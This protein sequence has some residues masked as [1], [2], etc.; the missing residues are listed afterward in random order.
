MHR[1]RL[2]D[3]NLFF[4]DYNESAAPGE[5]SLWHVAPDMVSI[6]NAGFH[7][8]LA[9]GAFGQFLDFF[10][11][12]VTPIKHT[13]DIACFLHLYLFR[14]FINMGTGRAGFAGHGEN[15]QRLA[16]MNLDGSRR[17]FIWRSFIRG[18]GCKRNPRRRK[19]EQEAG[20]H[21]IFHGVA[22]VG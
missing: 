22:Q 17:I 14:P 2:R 16:T 12:D 1:C 10:K 18:V 19:A 5:F 15:I 3:Y 21:K 6:L 13:I 4:V 8:R 11:P 9:V 7:E 20:Q